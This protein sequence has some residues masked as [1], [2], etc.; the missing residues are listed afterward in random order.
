MAV[1]ESVPRLLAE[2]QTTMDPIETTLIQQMSRYTDS[3]NIAQW[4]R[5]ITDALAESCT[6][7]GLVLVVEKQLKNSGC[8]RRG[9]LSSFSY[10]FRIFRSPRQII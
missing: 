8:I 1:L 2:A 7:G 10:R 5:W 6:T 9:L 4:N 3:Q